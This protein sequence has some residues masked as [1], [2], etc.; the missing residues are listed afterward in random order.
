[1]TR[2]ILT[3]LQDIPRTPEGDSEFLQIVQQLPTWSEHIRTHVRTEILHRTS[4]H[5]ELTRLLW[6]HLAEQDPCDRR[7]GGRPPKREAS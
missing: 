6:K 3:R 2:R 4:I 5:E 7:R 1:M